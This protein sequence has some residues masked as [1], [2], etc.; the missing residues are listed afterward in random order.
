MM[1]LMR[2]EL[3]K[4]LSTRTL[5]AFVLGGVAFA[6][7]NAVIIA[8]ASGTIDEVAEKQEALSSLPILPLLWGLVGAAGEYRHR[9]AAPAALVARCGRAALLFARLVA[10]AL[11]GLGIGVVTTGAAVA[12]ALPLLSSQPGPD[13]DSAQIGSMAAANVA[14]SA[15]SAIMGAALG[16]LVRNQV[17]G[18]VVLLV[19]NFAVI[20]LIAGTQEGLTNLTPFGASSVL[21]GMTH[22]TTITV[23]AAAAVLVGWT[24][25]V[26]FVALVS[27]R[28]RDLA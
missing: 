2:G 7:L 27:E 24:F 14:A 25:V 18:V 21:S 19:V 5:F 4:T 6:V 9:T 8:A 17:V 20:P 10:Y 26:G 11:T 3:A 12:V 28:Q 15:L 13:L 22:H 23:G 1:A 16:A